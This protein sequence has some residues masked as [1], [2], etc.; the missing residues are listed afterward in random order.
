MLDI[1]MLVMMIILCIVLLI[2]SLYLL[3]YYCHPDDAGFGSGLVCK[4]F[5]ILG[6][7]A[8]PSLRRKQHQRNRGW[9]KNGYHMANCIYCDSLLCFYYYPT[10]DLV[11]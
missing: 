10:V 5:A 4:I 7:S 11:L 2:I 1:F 8:A 3:V 9:V 6:L